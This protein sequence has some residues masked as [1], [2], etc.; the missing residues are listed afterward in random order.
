MTTHFASLDRHIQA[1]REETEQEQW[2]ADH[3]VAMKCMSFESHLGLGVSLF[4]SINRIDEAWRAKVHAK[5]VEYDPA[6]DEQIAFFYLWWFSPSDV[7]LDVLDYFES[8]GFQVE[9]ADR[10]RAACREVHGLLSNDTEFF[11]GDRLAQL[12]DDAIESH[13]RGECEPVGD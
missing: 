8:L 1:Y 3:D 13:R 7:L 6:V 5:Q 11:A 10:F 2:K 12:R 4:E 9:H